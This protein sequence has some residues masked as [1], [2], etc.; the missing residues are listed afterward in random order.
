MRS[1]DSAT[2]L[3][4]LQDSACIFCGESAGEKGEPLVS[5]KGL[6]QCKCAYSVHLSCWHEAM[7]KI[8][9][10]EDRLCPGCSKP[11]VPPLV[12]KALR[13]REIKGE[14]DEEETVDQNRILSKKTLSII[15]CVVGSIL[16]F[17]ISLIISFR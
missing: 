8:R 1:S 3:T 15:L 9:E 14:L 4:H 2:S 17:V 6:L 7:G 10:G 13:D 11:V 5:T 12:M 16:V